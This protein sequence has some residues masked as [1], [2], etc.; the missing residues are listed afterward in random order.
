MTAAAIDRIK[1]AG[2]TIMTEQLGRSLLES[3]GIL[4]QGRIPQIDGLDNK[5]EQ[6][7]AAQ[8]GKKPCK[9][10]PAPAI[11]QAQVA[12]PVTPLQH[13]QDM[14]TELQSEVTEGRRLLMVLNAAGADGLV[15]NVLKEDS[16][17]GLDDGLRLRKTWK[18]T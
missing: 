9:A 16:S 11:T 6:E 17:G 18:R 3:G 14:Q 2:S 10:A 4:G 5:G 1:A 8:L 15:S 12:E 7:L 13:A